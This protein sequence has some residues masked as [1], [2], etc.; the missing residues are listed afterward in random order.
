MRDAGPIGTEGGA[1]IAS[2][3]A[4]WRERMRARA[5]AFPTE[6]IVPASERIRKQVLA[7]PEWRAADAVAC[8]L[9]MER[10]VQTMKIVQQAWAE[11]KSVCV[12]KHDAAS[13]EYRWGWVGAGDR[14]V[15]GPMRVLEPALLDPAAGTVRLA[16]V[17]GVAFDPLGGR[18]GHGAGHY[19]RLLR[20][21][22]CRGAVRVGLAFH[23]QLA[24]ELPMAA[25][26]AP[27]D[28]VITEEEAIRRAGAR[29]DEG[30]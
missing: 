13:G 27:M 20:A 26:D 1:D 4:A 8:Y 22:P 15:F 9:A 2:R 14:L 5:R 21:A 11:G 3:K 7:L 10:E 12:P 18:L 19:D 16:L 24:D 30:G 6:R 23:W 28:W 17:P 25:N 29:T